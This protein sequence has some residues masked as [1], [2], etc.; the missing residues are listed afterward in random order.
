MAYVYLVLAIVAEVI[1]T[2][3]LKAADGFTKVVPSIVVVV[4]Y[5]TAFYLLS[6]ILR[7]I[8]VGVTYAIWS[9]VGIVLVAVVAAVTYKQ[10]PDLAALA[11]MGLIMAGVVVINLFSTTTG[12]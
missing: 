12:H 9:G 3:A 2:S 7:T 5:A 11:G 1:G 6:L 8:P 10:I 4:G